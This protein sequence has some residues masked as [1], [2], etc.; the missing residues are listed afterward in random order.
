MQRALPHVLLLIRNSNDVKGVKAFGQSNIKKIYNEFRLA[1]FD[2]SINLGDGTLNSLCDILKELLEAGAAEDDDG[3]DARENHVYLKVSELKKNADRE[4]QS[5]Q[6]IDETE[7]ITAYLDSLQNPMFH[8]PRKGRIFHWLY[9][10]GHE[11][12]NHRPDGGMAITEQMH[13]V[14]ATGSLEAKV[15]E[16][17]THHT[18]THEDTYQLAIFR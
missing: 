1:Y 16:M 2:T 17:S 10:T 12:A 3:D 7:L 6:V 15:A 8:N 14:F 13:A 4:D 5:V 18:M 11:T 9:R